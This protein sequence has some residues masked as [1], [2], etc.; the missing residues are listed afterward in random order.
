MFHIKPSYELQVATGKELATWETQFGNFR[1]KN[2]I[3]MYVN[4]IVKC[5]NTRIKQKKHHLLLNN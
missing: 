4:S 3:P 2:T 5:T 1:N